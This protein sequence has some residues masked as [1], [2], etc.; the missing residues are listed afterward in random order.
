MRKVLEG[1]NIARGKKNRKN[2]KKQV[3]RKPAIVA[4]TM[5]RRILL[6]TGSGLAST[7]VPGAGLGIVA[8]G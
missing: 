3:V 5:R 4:Q 1:S 7:S 8:F 6:T 2:I